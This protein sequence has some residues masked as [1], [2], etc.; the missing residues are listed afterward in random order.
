MAKDKLK[1]LILSGG[2]GERL[3]PFTFSGA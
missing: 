2:K 1:G 3:R